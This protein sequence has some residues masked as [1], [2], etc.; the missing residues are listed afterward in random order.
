M[1][2]SNPN[3]FNEIYVDRVNSKLDD[4]PRHLVSPRL[5]GIREP[6]WKRRGFLRCFATPP[7]CPPQGL[8]YGLKRLNRKKLTRRTSTWSNCTIWS[9]CMNKTLYLKDEDGPVWDK[10]R[11]LAGDKLSPVIVEGLKKFIAEKEGTARALERIVISYR[12]SSNG[13]IPKAKGFYG[14]WIIPPKTPAKVIMHDSSLN[15]SYSRY[16]CVAVT[17]KGGIVF[18][19][20]LVDYQNKRFHEF[21]K[22]YPSFSD[23]FADEDVAEAARLAFENFGVPV[24]EIEI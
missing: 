21:V 8:G 6:R 17:V 11:E 12:D 4:E 13:D 2:Y 19:G 18:Y 15:E 5:Y 3:R 20:W 14:A 1:S 22:A 10:A 7:K 16:F 9:K 23:A 24:E